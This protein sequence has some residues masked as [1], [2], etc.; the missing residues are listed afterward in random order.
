MPE[1]TGNFECTQVRLF[2]LSGV[3]LF[4]L[5]L[6]P[7]HIFEPRYRQMTADALT[8]DRAIAMA[9]PIVAH[10]PE[11]VPIHPVVCVGSI[12]QEHRLDDGRYTF[13]LRGEARVNIEE[14]IATD[15]MYRIAKV[16]VIHDEVASHLRTR[17]QL[18]RI[19]ILEGFRRLIPPD[20][21]F[22]RHLVTYLSG[23]CR[24]AAFADIVAYATPMPLPVKQM[25]LETA[26]VDFRLEILAEEVEKLAAES[27][28]DPAAKFPPSSS[29]N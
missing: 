28:Q 18:Q 3:V 25:L 23:G 4:P 9:Y 8:D 1:P 6:L 24:S 15:R 21:K 7:L 27:D 2:P 22:A 20:H 19:H 26:D 12:H 13:V 29:N 10:A 5:G 16:T 17:R 14:E 11:P